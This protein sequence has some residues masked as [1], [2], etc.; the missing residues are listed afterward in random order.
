MQDKKVIMVNDLSDTKTNYEELVKSTKIQH[1]NK[2]EEEINKSA[3]YG[4]PRFLP[5]VMMDKQHNQ[6][7]GVSY[8]RTFPKTGRNE[9]CPCKSGKKFKNCC[10]K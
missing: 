8:K 10:G 4:D 2:L 6:L 7:I 1:M 9:T 5:S 3:I